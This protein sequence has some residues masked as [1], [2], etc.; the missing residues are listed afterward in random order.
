MVVEMVLGQV[1]ERGR[2]H[3]DGVHAALVEAVARRLDRQVVDAGRG[4]PGKGLVQGDRVGRGMRKAAPDPLADDAE[5]AEGGGAPPAPQP[6]LAGE[7][8]H[9]GLSAGAGHSDD[10][11]RLGAVEPRRQLGE[12]PAR[13]I[14]G[15]QRDSGHGERDIGAGAGAGENGNGA[16]GQRVGDERGAVG[17]AAAQGGEQIARP[18]GARIGGETEDLDVTRGLRFA[19][20]QFRKQHPRP[21]R[22][23]ACDR[24]SR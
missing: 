10:D 17:P 7:I 19:G 20:E 21:F 5:R 15:D 22:P 3:L 13:V 23:R 24:R 11:A 16:A 2:G 4:D 14:G 9:R 12:T 8:G 6:D 1:G 18:H